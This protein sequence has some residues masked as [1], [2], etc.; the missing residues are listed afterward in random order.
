LSIAGTGASSAGAL[1]A[2][3]GAG[4]TSTYEG[5]I[6]LTG[7]TT[8][9]ASNNQL[10][11]GDGYNFDNTLS[12]GSNTLTLNTT[13]ATG[14]ATTYAPYPAYAMDDSNIII[15]SVI[16][17][18]GGVTKTGDGT[19]TLLYFPV[20][21]TTAYTGDTTI[22]AGTLVMG[23]ATALGSGAYSTDNAGTLSFGSL[24]AAS[25]GSL[26]GSTGLNLANDSSSAL[27]LTVGDNTFTNA[28]FSF[29]AGD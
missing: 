13:S 4:T 28:R 11:I 6:T 15:N 29:F 14:V 5:N 22:T 12:L 18:T 7:D 23:N 20:V 24:S 16:T 26:S 10:V 9:T 19:A 25:L 2:G 8:F 27:A 3:G 21:P 1:I 17:G